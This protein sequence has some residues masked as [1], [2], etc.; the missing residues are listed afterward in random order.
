M[1][2]PLSIS[3]EE[4][5]SRLQAV[6]N[7]NFDISSYEEQVREILNQVIE[8]GD[9]A[10][11][12]YTNRFDSPKIRLDNILVSDEEIHQAY[13]KVSNDFIK[14][15]KKSI[16]HVKAFHKKQ[17]PNSW[18]IT[19]E[20]GSIL[21]QLV[22]PVEAAGLYVPG[23]KGGNTPLC[24]SVVM[25]GIP[26]LIAGVKKIIMATPPNQ[27]GEISP[28]LIVAAKEVGIHKI[29]KM[30]SAWAIF[31]MAYGTGSVEKVDVIVGPGNIFVTIAK[32]MVSGK[33]GID[34]I[35]GPSE[36]L[37]IA[38]K[39]ANP[40]YIAADLLSQA[41][42]DTMATAILLTDS[43]ELADK[44]SQELNK[45][46]EKL[47]RCEIAQK[48][49]ETNSAL[50]I[51]EDINQAI[52][53]ANQIAPEHLELMVK[54]PWQL[55]GKIRHAGAIFLGEYTPEPIGDYI[56]GANHVL[57]TM[58]TAK[59]S[60]A[61]GVETFIKRSSIISYSK[62][63]FFNDAEDVIRLANVEGLG[64]HANS[65]SIRLE[66]NQTDL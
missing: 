2:K 3:T 15:L 21:G 63:A 45:Q 56:A 47:D 59:F 38:D 9:E 41:E 42:H 10:I 66:K 60:S 54:E 58:G 1:L 23:G 24:S 37:I 13:K 57:P 17:L 6:K 44:V 25:N 43:K 5:L 62:E 18:M 40:R 39:Y 7:R 27:E 20:D 4:G 19:R 11:V 55:V 8:K 64:A 53:I 61:L 12:E 46:L 65:I 30:G 22:K 32:K 51:V 35:A 14:S 48:S 50:L 49:L 36:I 52:N 26:A 29:Y 16:D 31:A 28:Y 34:M 33:V